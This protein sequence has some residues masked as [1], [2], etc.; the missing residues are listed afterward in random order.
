M[1]AD[2][3]ETLQRRHVAARILRGIKDVLLKL[4]NMGSIVDFKTAYDLSPSET[5]RDLKALCDEYDLAPRVDFEQVGRFIESGT[6][7]AS[8]AI[9]VVEHERQFEITVACDSTLYWKAGTLRSHTSEF[10]VPIIENEICSVDNSLKFN[11]PASRIL[12]IDG[13]S[14]R[15]WLSAMTDIESLK[16]WNT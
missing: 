2:T 9:P 1:E 15:D 11:M 8:G 6:L 16:D 5:G 14:V 13:A 4:M 10:M 7:C 12:G 3:P